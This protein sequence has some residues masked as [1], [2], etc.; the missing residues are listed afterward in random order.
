MK[1]KML[2]VENIVEA[3]V[4]KIIIGMFA[5]EYLKEHVTMSEYDLQKFIAER[6]EVHII[7]PL[8]DIRIALDES[9]NRGELDV[10]FADGYITVY[11]KVKR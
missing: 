3:V 6:P 7:L 8:S 5:Q 10:I 11:R 9:Y 4:D 2:Y 1:T